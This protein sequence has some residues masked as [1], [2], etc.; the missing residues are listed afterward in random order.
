MRPHKRIIKLGDAFL[1]MK[2]WSG[3]LYLI[4]KL[5]VLEMKKYLLAYLLSDYCLAEYKI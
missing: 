3:Y 5:F 2:A 4:I 1:S